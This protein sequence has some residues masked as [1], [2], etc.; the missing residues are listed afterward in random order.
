MLWKKQR[1]IIKSSLRAALRHFFTLPA[2]RTVI[3]A[4]NRAYMALIT[5]AEVVLAIRALSWHKV[6]GTD[7]LGIFL[8]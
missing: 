4:E 7:G 2:D 3:I 1:T 8:Q 5:E 6:L